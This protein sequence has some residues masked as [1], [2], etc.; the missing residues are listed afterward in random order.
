MSVHVSVR[1]NVKSREKGKEGRRR[2]EGDGLWGSWFSSSW[3]IA[4]AYITSPH[5]ERARG[6]SPLKA[7]ENVRKEAP[8]VLGWL[9][10][11]LGWGSG[12][13]NPGSR[14]SEALRD[15]P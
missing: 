12:P 11:E 10:R 5:Q 8:M 4:L 2:E 13:V 14:R 1:V 3:D 9:F 7:K 15:G 6:P